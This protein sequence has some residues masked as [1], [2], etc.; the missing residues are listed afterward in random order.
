MWSAQMRYTTFGVIAGEISTPEKEGWP[1]EDKSDGRSHKFV[2]GSRAFFLYCQD[3]Y[4]AIGIDF[5]KF[6]N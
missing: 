4:I 3:P 5:A 1:V 2:R 6:W